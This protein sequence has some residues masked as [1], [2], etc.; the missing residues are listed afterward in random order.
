M[1]G[2]D[3]MKGPLA[4]NVVA[5]MEFQSLAARWNGQRS[6]GVAALSRVWDGNF[7]GERSVV[8]RLIVTSIAAALVFALNFYLY[9]ASG[10]Y[11]PS[12]TITI[13]IL[14]ALYGGLYLALLHAVLLSVAVDYYFIP[15]IGA[16]FDSV[17]G[18]EHFLIVTGL[19]VFAALVGTSIRAAVR[20]T[21][22]ARQDAEQAAAIMEKVLALV[23]HD[24][25]SPLSGIQM[26]CEFIL[27][28][29]A[30]TA[31]HQST[32]AMMLRS[33]R[34]ADSMIGS[35]LDVASMRNGKVMPLRFDTCELGAEVGDALQEL[36]Q[37]VR[38]D[39]DFAAHQPIWGE[40]GIS[41]IRRALDN[42][43]TNAA[44]YGAS[45]TPITI[46]LQQENGRA[47]LSVH[48]HG[49]EIPFADQ[50]SL[51]QAF[52]R[53]DRTEN[54]ISRGWGLGLALVRGV[55]EAHGGTVSVVSDRATGTT[56]TLDLPIRTRK[57]APVGDRR[58]VDRMSAAD[59]CGYA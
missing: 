58:E 10:I 33:A 24:I 44:K 1:V 12:L 15:P 26:G 38:N 50:L 40:W 52:Q 47:L 41:G 45:D 21:V 34:R 54:R 57:A 11:F 9:G 20:R 3:Q 23:S 51:F 27:Q 17:A 7:V 35:L 37:M 18:Y 4:A 2:R 49:P 32:V 22:Q 43:V 29:P 53:A 19:A 31:K 59:L 56:F 13:I 16:V 6:T 28:H 30:R 46:K 36:S 39:L 42:L 14:I 55:A 48:N 5:R 8:K 25:R